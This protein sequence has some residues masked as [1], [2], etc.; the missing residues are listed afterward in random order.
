MTLFIHLVAVQTNIEINAGAG[1][2]RFQ[3]EIGA[4]WWSSWQLVPTRCLGDSNRFT[5]RT[6]Q[7]YKIHKEPASSSHLFPFFR[8][9]FNDGRAM[10][11]K[12]FEKK[13]FLFLLYRSGFSFQ[14]LCWTTLNWAVAELLWWRIRET[15]RHLV[16]S[17]SAAT[18]LGFMTS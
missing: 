16:I 17:D 13:N 7:K 10:N 6:A 15:T 5:G 2:D 14:I 9:V 11:G 8:K 3:V 12:S 1:G 4:R 18:L